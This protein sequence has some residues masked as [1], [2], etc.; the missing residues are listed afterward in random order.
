MVLGLTVALVFPL[1]VFAY[2]YGLWWFFVTENV[3]DF[4]KVNCGADDTKTLI[5]T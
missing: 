3:S 4:W 1:T 5:T 2:A